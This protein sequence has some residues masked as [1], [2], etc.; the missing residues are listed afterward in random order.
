MTP[1][2][3]T[4]L[5]SGEVLALWVAASSWEVLKPI[6]GRQLTPTQLCVAVCTLVHNW[7]INQYT[8]R[9]GTLQWPSHHS[10]H[11]T[12]WWLWEGMNKKLCV[13]RQEH[14][15]AY[16]VVERQCRSGNTY[17]HFHNLLCL[18]PELKR[19]V[20]SFTSILYTCNI[21]DWPAVNILK[22]VD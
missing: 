21:P 10:D 4:L 7:P 13:S 5:R 8:V 11:L 9:E 17:T 1:V 3:P 2:T 19:R 14:F 12:R 20:Y 22:P 6:H 16:N 15:I 18:G